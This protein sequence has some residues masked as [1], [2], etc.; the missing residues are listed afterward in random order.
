VRVMSGSHRSSGDLWY[1]CHGCG[2]THE[3]EQVRRALYL[4][5]RSLGDIE[6]AARGRLGRRL[7]RRAVTKRLLRTLWRS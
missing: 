3:V 6:A 4:G 5:Q 2:S 7:V 1:R